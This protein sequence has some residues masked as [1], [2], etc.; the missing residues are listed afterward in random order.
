MEIWTNMEIVIG[1]IVGGIVICAIAGG[2]AAFIF[3]NA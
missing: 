2:F 3:P 1:T